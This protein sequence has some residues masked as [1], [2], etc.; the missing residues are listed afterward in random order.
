MQGSGIT[1]LKSFDTIMS[2]LLHCCYHGCYINTNRQ[3]INLWCLQIADPPKTSRVCSSLN[4][5][6][7]SD[8]M[9]DNGLKASTHKAT[10]KFHA[11]DKTTE[12]AVLKHHAII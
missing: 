2:L 8:P 12:T 6:K 10:R 1:I 9:G 7:R 3:T 11:N 4:L 5:S